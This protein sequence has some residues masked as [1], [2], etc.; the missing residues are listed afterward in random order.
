M[1]ALREFQT[2][3][4]HTDSFFEAQ[5]QTQFQ[6]RKIGFSFG[7]RIAVLARHRD[8][9]QPTIKTQTNRQFASFDDKEQGRYNRFGRASIQPNT[10]QTYLMNLCKREYWRPVQR[11]HPKPASDSDK[12][13]ISTE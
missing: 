3:K 5:N 12:P 9:C 8:E 4:R 1:H 6:P 10:N 13:R 2:V 11:P 7:V